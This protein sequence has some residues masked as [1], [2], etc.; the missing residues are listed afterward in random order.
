MAEKKPIEQK[1]PVANSLYVHIDRSDGC[2][3]VGEL[4]IKANVP[5]VQG[6]FAARFRY[7]DEWIRSGFPIDPINLPLNSDWVDTQSKYIKLGGI[8]DAAP[9][10]WGRRV[11]DAT[12]DF[13]SDDEQKVLLMGRGTGV[14][15]LLFSDKPTLTRDGWPG[16]DSLA[17]IERDL[18]AIHEAVHQVC[19]KTDACQSQAIQWLAGSLAMGGARAKAV[20]RDAG[21]K[22]Y[23]AKFSEPHDK[24]DRQRVEHANLLMAKDIG[25]Q[26]PEC[27]VRDSHL[28]SVFIIE[29][30]DRTPEL[31]RKHYL[32]AISLVSAEPQ[33]KRFDSVRDQMIF[34]YAR[35]AQIA[36]RISENPQKD[37]LEIYARMLFNVCIKN[38]DD[39]MKNMG[40]IESPKGGGKLQLSPLFDV[41]TQPGEGLHFLRIGK[42]GRIG[43][44][45]NA[46]SEPE[47]FGIKRHVSEKILST[48]RDVV[49]ERDHYYRLV[50]LD[51]KTMDEVNRLVDVRCQRGR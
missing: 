51:A 6:G 33:S 28:G 23:I 35:I 36:S 19:L 38:T 9:D 5:K 40:F 50:G 15:A 18:P 29:R 41:V 22:I 16:F 3:L 11:I 21:N 39:H 7:A 2:H 25:L 49:A 43:S 8:F 27:R 10:L 44:V 12:G 17:R 30:F 4:Q 14:G 45:A 13:A 48:V 34:S 20:V 31:Q 37:V 1:A 32:S 26:V 42:E 24:Y 47:R 46:M